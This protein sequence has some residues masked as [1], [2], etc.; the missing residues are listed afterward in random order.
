VVD[1]PAAASAIACLLAATLSDEPA[2]EA[3]L[4]G[5]DLAGED[6]AAAVAGITRG[7]LPSLEASD[8]VMDV[9]R[10]RPALQP[11]WARPEDDS[12]Q[13]YCARGLASMLQ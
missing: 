7:L 8:S 13:A 5:L 9:V 2:V 12:E 4:A 1:D 11:R 3:S 6:A 10:V